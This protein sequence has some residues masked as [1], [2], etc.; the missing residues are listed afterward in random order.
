MEG[1]NWLT[2]YLPVECVNP[3][4][5]ISM[6]KPF[7]YLPRALSSR[8]DFQCVQQMTDTENMLQCLLIG[9]MTLSHV[10]RFLAPALTEQNFR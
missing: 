9:L 10:S 4:L 6:G 5:N 1:R 3:G 2:S 7:P 8:S